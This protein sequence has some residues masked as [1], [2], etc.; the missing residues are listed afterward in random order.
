[1]SRRKNPSFFSFI[2]QRGVILGQFLTQ[3]HPSNSFFSFPFI[4]I[5]DFHIYFVFYFV[6]SSSSCDLGLFVVF[7]RRCWSFCFSQVFDQFRLSYQIRSSAD[8]INDFGVIHVADPETW[9][10]RRFKHSHTY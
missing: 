10:F 7:V 2:H 6:I 5:S 3:N 1:M 4:E 8:P 9:L